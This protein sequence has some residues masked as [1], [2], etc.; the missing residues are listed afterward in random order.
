[1]LHSTAAVADAGLITERLGVSVAKRAVI[2][3]SI[4]PSL[5][6]ASR[7]RLAWV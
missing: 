3:V 1:M 4:N 5:D 6:W 2:S 7:T